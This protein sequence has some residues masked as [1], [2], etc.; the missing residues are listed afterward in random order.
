MVKVK[1]P[2]G[3]FLLEGGSCSEV[4]VIAKRVGTERSRSGK[5]QLST[6]QGP[7]LCLLYEGQCDSLD[8]V[9]LRI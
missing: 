8:S 9:L 5:A 3:A 7:T 4:S 6:V 1:L 2:R